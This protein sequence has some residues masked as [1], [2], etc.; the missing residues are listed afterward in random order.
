MNCGNDIN[1]K[2]LSSDVETK[3]RDRKLA[4]TFVTGNKKKY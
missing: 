3:K 2:I 4:I 1:E